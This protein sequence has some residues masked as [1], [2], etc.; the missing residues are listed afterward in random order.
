MGGCG[1]GSCSSE[2]GTVVSCCEHGN[3]H[4]SCIDEVFSSLAEQLLGFGRYISNAKGNL[5]HGVKCIS[6][7]GW[8]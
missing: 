5:P 1:L 2:Q 6:Y 7:E 3:E 4:V 8:M